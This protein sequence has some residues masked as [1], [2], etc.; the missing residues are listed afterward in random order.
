ML[1]KELVERFLGKN[2]SFLWTTTDGRKLYS[3]GWLTK[4]TN[5]SVIIEFKGKEQIYSLECLVNM[6]EIDKEGWR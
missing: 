5:S 3:K 1:E 4:V 6:R 2:I